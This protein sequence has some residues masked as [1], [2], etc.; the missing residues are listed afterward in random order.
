[1]LDQFFKGE[2]ADSQNRDLAVRRLT[3]KCGYAVAA[4]TLIPIPI[5]EHL[6]AVPI[7]VGMVIGIGHHYGVEMTRD[8]AQE[9]LLKIGASVGLSLA[10]SKIA[11]TAAKFILP[12]I[13]GL[14]VSAPL[15][16][17][18]TLAIG[19]VA[20]AYFAQSGEVTQS[21]LK[22]IYQR[23]LKKAKDDFNPSK[24]KS[25]EA[26]Q[27]AAAAAQEAKGGGAPAAAAPAAEPEQDS[28][29]DRLERLKALRDKGLI[30][31]DEYNAVKN[32]IL[33][34]L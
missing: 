7:H 26:K 15:M 10:G 23:S 31:E 16:Y 21:E 2:E 14:L 4:L 24:M 9:L 13:G 8:S 19:A 33:S 5:T 11:A 28:A 32:R 22:S 25:G 1:M 30:E 12:G 27:M 29:L 6:A 17:A 34:E 3:E 18:S 20:K